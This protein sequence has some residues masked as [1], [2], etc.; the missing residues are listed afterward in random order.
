M[1]LN[2][3]APLSFPDKMSWCQEW[4]MFEQIAVLNAR[5]VEASAFVTIYMST[6]P[7]L[8]PKWSQGRKVGSF[9][10][11]MGHFMHRQRIVV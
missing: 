7:S 1:P 9:T 5:K 3:Q 2:Q 11:V 10:G 4:E 8:G 6:T